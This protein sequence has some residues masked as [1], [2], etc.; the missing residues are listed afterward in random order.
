M[1]TENKETRMRKLFGLFGLV[2]VM[3]FAVIAMP[4]VSAD[5]SEEGFSA[6]AGEA[7]YSFE[8]ADEVQNYKMIRYVPGASA[9]VCEAAIYQCRV[10][11]TAIQ[12]MNQPTKFPKVENIDSPKVNKLRCQDFRYL[13]F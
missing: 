8:A 3:A 12:F 4:V 6:Y 5:S 9:L 7:L 11:G 2:V 13:K 10:N 1:I